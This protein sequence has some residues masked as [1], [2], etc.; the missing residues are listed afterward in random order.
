VYEGQ[1]DFNV[2]TN[3]VESMPKL[4]FKIMMNVG[5]PDRAFDFA[6]PCRTKVLVWRAWSSSSIA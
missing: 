1:L 4:P 3:S 5:N 6:R 2:K